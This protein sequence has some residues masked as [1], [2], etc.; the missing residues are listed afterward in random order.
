MLQA[1][2]EAALCSTTDNGAMVI[3][4]PEATSEISIGNLYCGLGNIRCNRGIAKYP[5]HQIVESR[6]VAPL[7]HHEVLTRHFAQAHPFPFC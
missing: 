5:V 6:S 2:T 4:M 7:I 1:T 3:P